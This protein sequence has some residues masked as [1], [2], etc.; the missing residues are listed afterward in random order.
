MKSLSG[1][2]NVFFFLHI[3]QNSPSVN[4]YP[5]IFWVVVSTQYAGHIT[6]IIMSKYPTHVIQVHFND[7]AGLKP[8]SEVGIAYE[9]LINISQCLWSFTIKMITLISQGPGNTACPLSSGNSRQDHKWLDLT[10]NF[11]GHAA[12]T[13]TPLS[14]LVTRISPNRLTASSCCALTNNFT[15]YVPNAI[16][17]FLEAWSA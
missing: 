17:K 8:K 15:H 5:S 1:V 13:L 7:S 10:C 4:V 16:R 9:L 12:K 2:P 6:L 14:D 11:C 3:Y